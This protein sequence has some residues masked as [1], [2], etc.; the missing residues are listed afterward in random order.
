[1]ACMEGFSEILI[2]QHLFLFR[3]C[4]GFGD[5]KSVKE[6]KRVGFFFFTENERYFNGVNVLIE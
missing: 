1:M 4:S 5:A 6:Q 3:L 2:G